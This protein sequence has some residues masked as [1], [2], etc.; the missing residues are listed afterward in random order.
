VGVPE[1]ELARLIAGSVL[2]EYQLGSSP[3]CEGEDPVLMVG[4]IPSDKA[5]ECL[6]AARRLV[7]SSGRWPVWV[8]DFGTVVGE[9]VFRESVFANDAPKGAEITPAAIVDRAL[10]A[11]ETTMLRER[12]NRHGHDVDAELEYYSVEHGPEPSVILEALEVGEIPSVGEVGKWVLDWRL[13][14]LPDGHSDA[15]QWREY[16]LDYW[17]EEPV[18]HIFF[19]PT[20]DPW[21]VTSYWGFFGS[22]GELSTL[23]LKKWFD[24]WDAKVVAHSGTMMNFEVGNPPKSLAEA[25]EVAW[26]H[27]LLAQCTT[28]LP[29]IPLFEY[30]LALVGHP[31]WSLH[32]KP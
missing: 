26:E 29:S 15:E 14:H 9:P 19:F 12:A 32:E 3:V 7:G 31:R 22:G 21:R 4:P 16:T 25:A 20:G 2:A 30:A 8:C 28:T 27:Y 17:H 23:L 24:R 1:A 6:G 11:D 18:G 10:A 13:R 5:Q